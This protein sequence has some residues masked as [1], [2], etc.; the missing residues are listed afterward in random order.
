MG[1]VS[2]EDSSTGG[3]AA[4]ARQFRVLHMFSGLAT[5]PDSLAAYLEKH[6]AETVNIDTINHHL[7]DQDL[8]DDAVWER[9]GK[10]Y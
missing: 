9:L 3:S 6:G 5:R 7:W 8:L 4:G 10:L 2:R 1:E